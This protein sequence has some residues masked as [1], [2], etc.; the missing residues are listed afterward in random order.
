MNPCYVVTDV[1]VDG[2]IPGQNSMLSFASVAIDAHGAAV[3][4][5]EAT[6]TP[7]DDGAADPDTM[8]WFRAHPEA[9][10]AATTDPKPA[11]DVM[12]R[13]VAWVR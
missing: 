12:H 6:L 13:Y 1:E 5:F 9:L 3:N 11:A 4:D 7:L 2:P 10:A 8:S